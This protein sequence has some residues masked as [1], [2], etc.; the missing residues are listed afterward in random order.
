MALFNLKSST[1]V[2]IFLFILLSSTNSVASVALERRDNPQ[3]VSCDSSCTSL[4]YHDCNAAFY[5]LPFEG[6][7]K[8][9]RGNG[10]ISDSSDYGTCRVK[11]NCKDTTSVSAGRLLNKDGQTPGFT[12]LANTCTSQGQPGTT[13]VD[14]NCYIQT[15]LVPAYS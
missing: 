13:W 1:F 14:A 12:M 11:V 2:A 6:E 9:L 10:V 3:S 8:M 15:V 7:H 4:V 5:N